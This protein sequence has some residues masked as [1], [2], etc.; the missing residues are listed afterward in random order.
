MWYCPYLYHDE[1]CINECSTL[2][3]KNI[4]DIDDIKIIICTRYGTNNSSWFDGV[5]YVEECSN[6]SYPSENW[7]FRYCFCFFST[8]IY[9]R[10]S[11]FDK[12]IYDEI[13]GVW[14][15]YRNN[16]EYKRN[17]SNKDLEI[18]NENPTIWKYFEKYIKRWKVFN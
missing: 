1:N 4:V 6:V 2:Y 9:D 17:I 3:K 8:Y 16:C 14:A 18:K 12:C 11:F 10:T 5:E 15:K 13:V 7:Y